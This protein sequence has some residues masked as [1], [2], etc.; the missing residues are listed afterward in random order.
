MNMRG[1]P[2]KE[3]SSDASYDEATARSLWLVSEELTGVH[4]TALE[5]TPVTGD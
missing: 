4:Y 3:K 2:V 5:K 1:Y